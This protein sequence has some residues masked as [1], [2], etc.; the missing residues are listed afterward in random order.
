MV[1]SVS[2]TRP[3]PS[4]SSPEREAVGWRDL[5]A[6]IPGYDSFAT[7]APGEWFDEATADRAVAFFPECLVHVEGKVAGQPFVLEP[8]QRAIVGA[9]F[10]WKRP[11]GTRRYREAL[12]YVPRKNGKTPM[13][14][15]IATYVLFCDAE[16][17]QQD[18]LAAG[19]REQASL[20]FR[21]MNGMIQHEPEL[22]SRCTVF[23]AAGGSVQKAITRPDGSSCKVISADAGTKHGGNLHLGV[24][25]EL[26]VQPN[27]DLVDVIQTSMASANRRQPLLIHITTADF[28]RE[29]I[30]N[31][32]HDYASKVRDGIISDP[33]FLPVIYE[34]A[35]EDDWKDERV[36]AAANPNLGVSVSLDYLRR[37]CK[38]AID[39]PGYENT[40]K[41]LHLNVR[42]QQDVRWLSS[43]AWAACIGA[44]GP[45][46]LAALEE[47]LAGRECFGALD[48][49]SK[50]D[51]SCW[52]MLFPPMTDDP[53]WW[54]L[55]RFFMP[56]DNMHER[57]NRDRVPFSVWV[58]AGFV[59]TTPGNVIDY[60]FIKARAL[61]DARRFVVREIAYDSWNATQ[62]ALQLQDQG[63]TMI[64]FG[65]GY[66]SM[67][68]PSKELEKLVLAET[69]AHGGNPVMRWMAA[70]VAIEQDPAG[71]IKPSKKKSTERI[72]GI[73][74]LVMALGRAIQQDK[75][76]SVYDREDVKEL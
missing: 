7:A 43:E 61:D 76:G 59:T 5:L 37:E 14:A 28:D 27:R 30:C 45:L 46:S 70:N 47:R 3:V 21:Q 50:T 10:G 12:I 26:H 4:S 33:A 6:L 73:V 2:S 44:P 1:K 55:P 67:S 66:R 20:L 22:A 72:D 41:R 68:E 31:E 38:R 54:F 62:I 65:Q 64:E 49:S 53:L 60:E 52:A 69:L 25:D 56:G 58:R 18:V 17:G 35:P 57:E 34:A 29:S 71:N 24:I 51:L 16:A 75:G 32:K 36:W 23:G 74:T 42:T 8:W 39:T 19:D 15:G 63:A 40:F 11:D 9:M 13:V 48:L